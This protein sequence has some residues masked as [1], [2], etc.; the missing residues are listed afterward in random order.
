MVEVEEVELAKLMENIQYWF[1]DNSTMNY[2][3]YI[4]ILENSR[5]DEA[6]QA[7][8]GEDEEI[9]KETKGEEKE[10]EEDESPAKNDE[11]TEV[12]DGEEEIKTEEE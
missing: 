8:L 12:E 11:E 4:K 10:I 7:D 1:D 3:D 2:D 9:I 5:T 6:V